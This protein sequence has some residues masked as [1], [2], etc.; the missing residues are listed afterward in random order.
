MLDD[1]LYPEIKENNDDINIKQDDYGNYSIGPNNN[2]IN[3]NNNS[4]NEDEEI[5]EEEEFHYRAVKP[6]IF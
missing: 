1:Y 4:M 3:E 5:N 2:E 6:I